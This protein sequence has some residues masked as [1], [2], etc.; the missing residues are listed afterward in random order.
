MSWIVFFSRLADTLAVSEKAMIAS[1]LPSTRHDLESGDDGEGG[2]GRDNYSDDGNSTYADSDDDN[3]E[4][5]DEDIV[6]QEY[7]SSLVYIGCEPE[8][9][10]ARNRSELA[11]ISPDSDVDL[12]SEDCQFFSSSSVSRDLYAS[13]KFC[14]IF[15]PLVER[16]CLRGMEEA[17]V[18]RLSMYLPEDIN[19]LYEK[20]KPQN[21]THHAEHNS[22]FQVQV[23]EK[24]A[25]TCAEL[26]SA[27]SPK[28]GRS[29]YFVPRRSL[30]KNFGTTS[31]FTQWK[32]EFSV[33]SAAV[34][35]LAAVAVGIH[36]AILEGKDPIDEAF[37]MFV[38]ETMASNGL[39]E[40]KRLQSI[41]CTYEDVW[42]AMNNASGSTDYNPA[43]P[44][45]TQAVHK[46]FDDASAPSTVDTVAFSSPKSITISIPL[47]PE[48]KQR[49]DI[50]TRARKM[51]VQYMN[52]P[53]HI[54]IRYNTLVFLK[55]IQEDPDGAFF[56]ETSIKF[57][58]Y[59][60]SQT[61]TANGQ[62]SVS[63]ATVSNATSQLE[64]AL[65]TL[66]NVS[67]SL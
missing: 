65:K 51:Y 29:L 26:F 14:G 22:A 43:S 10:I 27:S 19:S 34:C 47:T 38:S 20:C 54:A 45:Q 67:D 2:G 18:Y 24:K 21:G 48:E 46:K 58:F 44:P 62:I 57:F 42:G 59:W 56:S 15:V 36:E 13:K 17:S 64:S 55:L 50:I 35:T 33:A 37:Q 23:V 4:L 63:K 7:N 16:L 12:T 9:P 8:A 30:L 3:D 39:F 32:E 41:W 31:R 25:S 66:R 53:P 60:L 5:F 28:N 49:E 52:N 6:Q 61:S 40:M 1:A 11:A